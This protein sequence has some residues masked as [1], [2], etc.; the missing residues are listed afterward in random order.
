M[1]ILYDDHNYVSKGVKSNRIYI[2]NVLDG[3]CVRYDT[4]HT[5]LVM[6]GD[7]SKTLLRDI[8]NINLNEMNNRIYKIKERGYY[9]LTEKDL[10]KR[11]LNEV[12]QAV[13]WAK[14]GL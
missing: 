14:L 8:L 3:P 12:N 9:S 5:W 4:D 1:I 6:H 10:S 11:L 7:M 2:V 13:L